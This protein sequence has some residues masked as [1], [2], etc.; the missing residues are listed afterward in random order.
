ML[1]RENT[2]A[3]ET[4][5]KWE[6]MVVV[7]MELIFVEIIFFV[8]FFLQEFIFEICPKI[9][10]NHKNK[11]RY[12]QNF[13]L[14]LVSHLCQ[15]CYHSYK[16]QVGKNFVYKMVKTKHFLS[17]DNLFDKKYTPVSEKTFCGT[18]QHT[19]NHVLF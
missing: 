1:C 7:L 3:S 19:Y 14:H 9:C 15:N 5:K 13:L 8:G 10:K 17:S 6:K 12:L 18:I 16:Y 11:Y 2:S 4:F